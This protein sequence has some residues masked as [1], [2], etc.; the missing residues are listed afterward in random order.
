MA[1][2]STSARKCL[3]SSLLGAETAETDEA[4]ETSMILSAMSA[5][6]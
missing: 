3:T 6:F 4:V 1:S 5:S 2:R